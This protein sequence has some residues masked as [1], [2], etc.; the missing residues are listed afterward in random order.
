MSRRLNGMMTMAKSSKKIKKSL[1]IMYRNTALHAFK[2]ITTVL[3]GVEMLENFHQL[4]KRQLVKEYIE[5]KAAEFVYKLF[6]DEMKEVEEMYENYTKISPPMP[7]SLPKYSGLAIWALSLLSRI[8]SAKKAID[9]LF[10]IPEHSNKQEAVDKYDKLHQ[11]LDSFIT[12]T[13]FDLWNRELSDKLD[14][15][16]IDDKLKSPLLV[17]SENVKDKLP[18]S[19]ISNPIFC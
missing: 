12:K 17:R 13:Q 16:N 2:N 14:L 10:F 7:P 18:D 11:A 4:A 15:E 6:M 19:L 3:E 9:S 1:E 8:E 5:T